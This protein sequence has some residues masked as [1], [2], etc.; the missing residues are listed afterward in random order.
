MPVAA[1]ALLLGACSQTPAKPDAPPARHG[2]TSRH[3]KVE[4]DTVHYQLAMGQVASGGSP[5][6]RID[7]TYPASLLPRCPAPVDIDA[8]LIVDT[9]GKVEEVRVADEAQADAERKLFIAA[10][11]DAAKQWQFNPL[12]I[13]YWTADANGE[14]HE[15]SSETKPF[16]LGYTFHF[17]CRDGRAVTHVAQS[18]VHG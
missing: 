12:T 2:D 4:K 7:P 5:F 15:T 17:E 9:D 14:Q 16:S 6:Q 8:S 11:R 18:Q 13:R 10:A 1:I 3:E